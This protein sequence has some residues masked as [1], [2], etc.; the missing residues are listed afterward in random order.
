[1]GISSSCFE[2]PLM[3][4]FSFTRNLFLIVFLSF[5]ILSAAAIDD[6]AVLNNLAWRSIGPAVMGGRISDLCGVPAD[7]STLYAAA[8]SGG[9]FRTTDAGTTW[10]PIFD[11]ETTISIGAIAL[12]PGNSK[13]IW[14]GTGESNLRNSVSFGD[15]IYKSENA[16]ST[17]KRMGLENTETI[18]RIVIDPG[19][20]DNV[21]VAAVGHPFGPNE[22]RGVFVTHDGGKTWRKTLYIDPNHGAVGLEMDP[23]QPKILYVGMWRFDRKPWTYTSGSESGGV[24]KSADGGETWHKLT[25]GLPKLLGRIGVKVAPSNPNIVY[26]I[27]ESKEGTLFRSSD[28]GETFERISDDR[29]LVGRAYYFT[30]MRIS[31]ENQDHIMVLADALLESSDGGKHFHRM[32]TGIHG[33]LHALWIDPKDPRRIWQGNDGGL[34]VTYDGGSHWEQVNNIPLG[35]FYHASADNRQPFYNVTVGMQDNG[36]WTGPSRTRE[37]SGIFNDDWRMVNPYTGFNSLSESDDPDILLTEQPGGTLLRTD[38]RTREQQVVGPQP[39]SYSGAPAAEMKYR[40][41]W[42]APLVRSMYGKSTIYLAGNVVFQSTDYGNSWE[43]IS[44]DLTNHDASR[45][46]NIGGPISIDNSASEV[47][48]TVTS[49][50]ESPVMRNVLWAGTDDGNIQ[51]TTDGGGTWNSV[52]GNLAGVPPSSPVSHVEPS[53]IN[54]QTAYVSLDRHMFDD[55]HPYIFKTSDGGRSFTNISKNLPPQAF[56]WIIREDPRQPNLLYAGTELGL[57]ASFSGGRDWVPLHLRNMPWSVAVRD[58]VIQ[59]TTNDLLIAT[60]GRSLWILDDASFLQTLAGLR[61]NE[62]TFFP[63]RPALRFSIRASRFG[64]GDKTFIGPN[65]PY[66]ALLTYFLPAEAH[67]A[68]IQIL[69]S[70][71]SVIRSFPCPTQ[72][73]VSRTAWD[74]RYEGAGGR[75]STNSRDAAARGPQAMPGRYTARLTVDGRTYDQPVIVN[76]D[77][78]LHVS[79]EDL[80]A[81][82]DVSRQ[83]IEMQ[84]AVNAA[85][86]TLGNAPNANPSG[87]AQIKAELTRP[88][89]LRAQTG[90]KLRDNLESLFTMIDS[91]NA[92]PTSAQMQYFDQLKNSFDDDMKK[93]AAVLNSSDSGLSN[94]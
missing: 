41:N 29:E 80:Q 46:G 47:Y 84:N 7:P 68:R 67:Q 66:G 54:A 6:P 63:V 34:A 49:L 48:S 72:K 77:P 94:K 2:I 12:Q 59:P 31:P 19:N 13:V 89:S 23:A 90:P 33:D 75:A 55:M 1:M 70:S 11:H 82:F 32:S 78:E 58:I 53:K 87:V 51:V 21:I 88:P 65:P 39:R 16:G 64:F 61:D 93:V 45:L 37:P 20:P 86:A 40:F 44:H 52:A 42:D 35:Q 4:A 14:V 73:G 8:G 28:G 50:A 24:F 60:H 92:A 43:A 91:V 3:P 76:L 30:D 85:L 69:D 62:P 36:S 57:Y 83:L 56:V 10:N 74:L 5:P 81:Q 27:A 79:Q 22:E 15:G 38:M 9:L 18:S 25:H 17:W 26:V 71:G